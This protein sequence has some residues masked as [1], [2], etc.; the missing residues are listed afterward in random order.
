MKKQ[1][2]IKL[3]IGSTSML[4]FSASV[5]SCGSHNNTQPDMSQKEVT[6]INEN[7]INELKPLAAIVDPKITNLKVTKKDH[8]ATGLISYTNKL[9]SDSKINNYKNVPFS[10]KLEKSQTGL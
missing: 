2:L 1:S 7:L 5:I 4:G 8:L 10:I 6:V 9:I 3:I